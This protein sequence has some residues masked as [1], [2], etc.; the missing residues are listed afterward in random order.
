MFVKQQE[1]TKIK[2]TIVFSTKKKKRKHKKLKFNAGNS[3]KAN[4][5]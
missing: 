4:L 3:G 5:W 1:K 2:R